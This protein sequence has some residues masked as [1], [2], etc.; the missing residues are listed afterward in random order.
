M[1][2]VVR[3]I[4]MIIIKVKIVTVAVTKHLPNAKYHFDY[5]TNRKAFNGST[6]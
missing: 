6:T 2:G 5:F 4:I 1:L 3:I